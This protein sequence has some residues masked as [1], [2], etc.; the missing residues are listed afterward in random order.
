[1]TINPFILHGE[2]LTPV[3]KLLALKALAG[4]APLSEYTETGN[5]VSFETNVAK[6]LSVGAAFTPVQAGSG[7]PSPENVRPISGWSG[8]KITHTGTNMFNPSEKVTGKALTVS[9]DSINESTSTASDYYKNICKIKRGETYTISY[10]VADTPYST[11]GR[12]AF[13]MIDNTH[14]SQYIVIEGF[15]AGYNEQT[16]TA[17]GDGVLWMTVGKNTTNLQIEIG[18]SATPFEEYT[19]NTVSVTFP[20]EA[21]TVYGGT[22]DLTTGVLTVDK[23]GVSLNNPDKWTKP[24]SNLV[25]EVNFNDRKQGYRWNDPCS[26]FITY[27]KSIYTP[28]L[29]WSGNEI[30]RYAIFVGSS[31]FTLDEVKALATAEKIF[32]V[33]DLETPLVYQLTPVEILSLVGDNVLWSDLNGNL[34]V[35]Y[36]KKG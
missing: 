35:V 20:A 12:S 17:T 26:C 6:P 7:D 19:G 11:S 32:A 9:G 28:Y 13:V 30:N 22:L 3:R 27:S 18:S 4:G 25:Y 24:S 1:M 31:G 5:P 36:K 15:N 29:G 10:T 33:Y 23:K 8:A 34:T 2:E 21:G 16:F 14:Y